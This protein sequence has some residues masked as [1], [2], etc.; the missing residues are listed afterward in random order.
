MKGEHYKY[1]NNLMIKLK[2]RLWIKKIKKFAK[3]KVQNDF[4]PETIILSLN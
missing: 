2:I 3:L 1:V 4:P